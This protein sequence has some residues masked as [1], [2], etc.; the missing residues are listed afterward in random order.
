VTLERA[1]VEAEAGAGGEGAAR[2]D[3][4][5]GREAG[6]DP[7]KCGGALGEGDGG[8]L[9]EGEAEAEREG[10]AGWAPGAS[11]E[12]GDGTKSEARGEGAESSGVGAELPSR[13]DARGGW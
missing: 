12:E 7:A 6:D 4:G 5:A 3:D 13:A 10:G 11:I 8:A 2:E 9:G 1:G